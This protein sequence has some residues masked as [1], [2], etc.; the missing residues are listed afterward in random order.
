[1]RS[2]IGNSCLLRTK[3]AGIDRPAYRRGNQ[4]TDKETRVTD[5]TSPV[6]GVAERYASALFELALDEKALAEI[7][8]ALDRFQAMLTESE[9]LR[10]MVRSPV[11]SAQEHESAIGALAGL[12][13][14]KGLAANFVQLL[15]RNRRLFALGDVIRAF[16]AMAADHRDEISA[17]VTSARPLSDAQAGELKAV[18]KARLGKDVTLTQ[19]VEPALL[20]GLVVRVGSRMIDSSLRT[21]LNSMK[22]RLKEAS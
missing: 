2:G 5:Q 16:K 22:T 21:K 19:A 4:E 20:G 12:A 9:D 3:H 18:L 10:R 13:G 11:I 1:M 14:I 17:S 7:E 15:A 8:P 6:S